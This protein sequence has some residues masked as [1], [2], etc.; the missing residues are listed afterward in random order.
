VLAYIL[1][2]MLMRDSCTVPGLLIKHHLT[3]RQFDRR[4][5]CQVNYTTITH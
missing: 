2:E 4:N 1:I 3:D 5:N